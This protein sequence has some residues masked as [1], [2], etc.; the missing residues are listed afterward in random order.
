[1]PGTV[2]VRGQGAHPPRMKHAR[3]ILLCFDGS[4]HARRAV[5]ETAALLEPR[6]AVVLSV[7]ERARDLSP[8]DPL[9]DAIGRLSEI[10]AELDGIGLEVARRQAEEGVRLAKRLFPDVRPRVEC[11]PVAQTIVRVAGE[12]DAAAI[13]LGARGRSGPSAMLGSVSARVAR[14]AHR[15]V[16]VV[17]PD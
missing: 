4:E 9:G 6:P 17:P 7:W 3:P 5:S 1:V 10:Y 2:G 15:P 11:G 12:E 14:H 16:F 13:A 8:L